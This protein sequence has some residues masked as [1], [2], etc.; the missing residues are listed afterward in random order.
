MLDLGLEIDN[1]VEKFTG[2]TNL[3]LQIDAKSILE[4]ADGAARGPGPH[5]KENTKKNPKNRLNHI[6]YH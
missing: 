4:D 1:L 3:A 2:M 6:K 5:T